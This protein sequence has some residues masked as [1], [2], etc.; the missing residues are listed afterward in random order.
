MKTFFYSL[1]ALLFF[2]CKGPE[3]EP[4]TLIFD[5]DM[6]NDIDDAIA[7]AIMNNYIDGGK[8]RVVGI[9]LSKEGSAP[10]A[11][12]DIVQTWY[13]HAGIPIGV[14]RNSVGPVKDCYAENVWRQK[15]EEGNPLFSHSLNNDDYAELPDA[16]LL[17]RKLLAA[18]PD[19]SVTFVMV[20]FSTNLARLLETGSDEYSPLE[21]KELVA[22]KVKR[23]V[24]MAGNFKKRTSEY[25]VNR[26]LLAAQKVFEEWPTEIIAS[27]FEVGEATPFPAQNVVRFGGGKPNPVAEGYKAYRKMPYDESGWDPSAMICGVEGHALFT[28]SPAGY[29]CVDSVGVT[30]F[31]PDPDK[32]KAHYLIVNNAQAAALSDHMVELATYK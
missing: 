3:Q 2:A 11:Y 21:G 8:A 26:D 18:E 19:N 1:L 28:L 23:L 10:A 30:T 32:G 13:G 29:I 7:L 4:V 31:N 17:Y 14:V 16:H 5:T 12:V 20:G 22:K 15:D 24:C 9:G 25:N 6:G 27:P